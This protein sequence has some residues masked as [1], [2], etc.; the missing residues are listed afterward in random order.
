MNM[1]GENSPIRV[2]V[3]YTVAPQ[4]PE[5]NVASCVDDTATFSLDPLAI[6]A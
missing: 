2:N 6:S 5:R 4:V 3:S 1:Q